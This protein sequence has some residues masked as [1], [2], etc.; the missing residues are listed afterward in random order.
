[1]N[2]IKA[3]AVAVAGLTVGSAA[4]YFLTTSR[5]SATTDAAV[6]SLKING[7]IDIIEFKHEASEYGN[8]CTSEVQLSHG[9]STDEGLTGDIR[10][11]YMNEAETEPRIAYGYVVNGKGVVYA[12]AFDWSKRSCEHTTARAY[13]IDK[14]LYATVLPGAVFA[15]D[16]K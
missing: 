6:E 15:A 13:G 8:K 1:M 3:I 7:I 12:Q 5:A 10:V 2:S 11:T 16:N 4:T 9:I 14:V